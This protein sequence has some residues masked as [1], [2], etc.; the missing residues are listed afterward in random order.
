MR[1]ISYVSQSALFLL[2]LLLFLLARL[3]AICETRDE[4]LR[5]HQHG[6]GTHVPTWDC[7]LAL[8]VAIRR[9][10]ITSYANFCVQASYPMTDGSYDL[11]S[12]SPRMHACCALFFASAF[13]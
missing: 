8:L 7:L 2:L 10:E 9:R 13:T 3:L 4:K 11:A 6:Y 5:R 12:S 1:T